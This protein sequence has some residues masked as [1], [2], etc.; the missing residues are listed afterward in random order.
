M[1]KGVYQRGKFSSGPR[2]LASEVFWA[3]VDKQ[4]PIYKKLGRCWIWLG[5]KYKGK[6]YGQFRN[7]RAHRVSWTLLIGEIEENKQVLHKCDNPICV[8]P[9]HLFVGTP[10]DNMNDKVSK[11]RQSRVG[12]SKNPP[13]GE[14][15][16]AAK[17]TAEK[18][19]IARQLFRSGVSIPE[20]ES[21]IESPTSRGNLKSAIL[22]L[23]WRHLH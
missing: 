1:P 8:N 13:K 20:I 16:R 17:L 3:Q 12:S 18:V 6:D 22:G 9:K 7:K 5:C 14:R 4:G 10:S 11:G 2:R 23:T 21:I 19:T 15:N